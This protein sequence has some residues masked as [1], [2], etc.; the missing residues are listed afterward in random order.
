MEGLLFLESLLLES[1]FL[2]SLFLE[3]LFRDGSTVFPQPCLRSRGF[4]VGDFAP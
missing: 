1:L 2:E 4:A 3:R